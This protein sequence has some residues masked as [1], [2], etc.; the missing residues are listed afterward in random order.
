MHLADQD[1]E[2][3]D[4]IRATTERHKF[5]IG[6]FEFLLRLVGRYENVM[7]WLEELSVVDGEDPDTIADI[8]N[9]GWDS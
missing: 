1:Q 2:R 6:D 5:R 3:L 4:Q 7:E 8:L 9:G